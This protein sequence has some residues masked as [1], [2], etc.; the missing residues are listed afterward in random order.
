MARTIPCSNSDAI[1]IEEYLE[2]VRARVDLRDEDSIAA[3]APKLRAL[4]NDRDLI[5]R[6]LNRRIEN[7]LTDGAL[8]SAQALLIGVGSDDFYVRANI[9]PA[10]SDMASGRAYQDQFAYNLAHDHNFTFMT[11]NYL[12]PGYETEIYEYDYDK[13]VGYVGEPVDLRFNEK[14]RFGTGTVMLYRASRDVHVQ[15]APTELT[16]TLNLMVSHPEVRIRD[17]YYFDLTTRTIAGY[18]PELAGSSRATL[19]RL[20]GHLGNGDTSQLLSDIGTQ[21]PDRRTRLT[22]LE[23]LSRT[24]PA[25]AASIWEKASSDPAPLVAN[26]ARRRL[27]DLASAS[28]GA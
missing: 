22:A 9:W 8:L 19:L 18:P 23:A 20:A 2:H 15:F 6:E 13:V 7:Y 11:V 17:Q 24:Q 5:V 3:S 28:G 16:I 21:H 26:T 12:G 4:A 27:K 25:E 10:I 1:S 14:V